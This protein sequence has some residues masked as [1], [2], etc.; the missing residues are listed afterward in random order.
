MKNGQCRK[1]GSHL[2]SRHPACGLQFVTDL[3]ETF[4]TLTSVAKLQQSRGWACCVRVPWPWNGEVMKWP[5]PH[6]SILMA[7]SILIIRLFVL[8]AFGVLRLAPKSMPSTKAE[9]VYV[10]R[11]QKSGQAE[12][13][14]RLPANDVTKINEILHWWRSRLEIANFTSP[15]HAQK[16]TK[17]KQKAKIGDAT[18]IVCNRF[19]FGLYL[20]LFRLN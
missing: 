20:L 11:P 15:I 2:C 10:W 12:A 8:Y 16:K 18:T 3:I 5:T 1:R 6:A 17:G 4:Y 13:V 19:R 7:E 9:F 14:L